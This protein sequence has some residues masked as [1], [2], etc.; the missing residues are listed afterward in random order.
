MA[1]ADSTA[2]HQLPCKKALADDAILAEIKRLMDE[3][4]T[5]HGAGLVT[6]LV[7]YRNREQIEL[8]AEAIK[9]VAA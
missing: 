6:T 8:N 7:T 2:A 4:V 9:E 5:H 3:L 1:T